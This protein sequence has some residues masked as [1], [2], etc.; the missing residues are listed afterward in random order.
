[1][2]R[3]V[4]VLF[5][6]FAGCA[7]KDFTIRI[8]KDLSKV[9]KF[10]ELN[11]PTDADEGMKQ[12]SQVLHYYGNSDEFFIFA[13]TKMPGHESSIAKY[14]HCL[15]GMPAVKVVWKNYDHTG[16][17]I[18]GAWHTG[19]DGN[20]MIQNPKKRWIHPIE[21]A[22]NFMHEFT[23]ACGFRHEFNDIKLHPEILT[24]FSYQIGYVFEDFLREIGE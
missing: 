22:G 8:P 19:P 10:P 14:R 15:E 20:Y 17:E 18:L 2:N 23:H 3:F 13:R 6:V 1:M 5:L 24:S 9:R 4:F 7:S 16:R 11:L 12:V 21:R